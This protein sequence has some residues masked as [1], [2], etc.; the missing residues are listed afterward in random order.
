[1]A[2]LFL[3]KKEGEIKPHRNLNKK[4]AKKK[5]KTEDLVT[6]SG[7]QNVF[8][9]L[10]VLLTLQNSPNCLACGAVTTNL[11]GTLMGQC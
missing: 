7:F 11:L 6:C 8:V 3:A 4:H 1:M 5:K 9:F 10:V 2:L